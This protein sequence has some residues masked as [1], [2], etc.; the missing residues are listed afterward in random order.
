MDFA[1]TEEQTMLADSLAKFLGHEYGFE[2]RG[3]IR[4]SGEGF[5]REVW[6]GFAEM[7]LLGLP[8]AEEYGGFGGVHCMVPAGYS[9]LLAPQAAGLDVRLSCPVKLVRDSQE[10]VQVTT[11]SGAPRRVAHVLGL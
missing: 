11:E 8:F 4:A 1:F 7:G 9:S 3:A 6:R 5:S 2:Q 10:G